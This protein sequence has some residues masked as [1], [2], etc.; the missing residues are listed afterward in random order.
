MEKR[1][2]DMLSPVN[3]NVSTL[4]RRIK[5]LGKP[6]DGAAP[7]TIRALLESLLPL[8]GKHMSRVSE[9]GR[10]GMGT[11]DL[12]TDESLQ[13]N[14]ARKI[15]HEELQDSAWMVGSFIREAQITAQLEH[16]NILPVH[17]IGRTDD[18]SESALRLGD[19]V[20]ALDPGNPPIHEIDFPELTHQDVLRL[21]VTM[22]DTAAVG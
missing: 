9:I 19:F 8:G 5:K 11:I 2:P 21:D 7:P 4:W 18:G 1:L 22:N 16:P 3:D 13:R 10:G 14:V 17:E 6:V 20:L 12:V 15:V